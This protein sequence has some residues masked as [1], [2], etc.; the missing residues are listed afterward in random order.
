[1]KTRSTWVRTLPLLINITDSD[2]Y[3]FFFTFFTFSCFFCSRFVTEKLD[4]AHVVI[5]KVTNM[6]KQ[7]DA[8]TYVS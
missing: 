1:M 7:K 5:N 6:E 3:D 4:F 8:D 2:Q